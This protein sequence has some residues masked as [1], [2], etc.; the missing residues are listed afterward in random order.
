LYALRWPS[1]LTMVFTE[2]MAA[3]DG[4]SSSTRGMAASLNGMETALPRMPSA[5]M[6]VMAPGRSWVVKALYT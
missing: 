1:V 2:P 5:R 6:P 3:A 4:S